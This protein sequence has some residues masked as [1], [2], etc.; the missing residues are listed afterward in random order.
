MSYVRG[1]S[2]VDIAEEFAKA[3][4]GWEAIEMNASTAPRLG[5]FTDRDL[6]G[7]WFSHHQ[8]YAVLGLLSAQENQRR[9]RN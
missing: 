5:R 1:P 7:R 2:F 6:A 4:G 8:E 9:P 3:V